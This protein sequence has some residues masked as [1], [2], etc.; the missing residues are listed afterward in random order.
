LV[1]ELEL[2]LAVGFSLQA[3]KDTREVEARAKR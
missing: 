2:E 3:A 1:L